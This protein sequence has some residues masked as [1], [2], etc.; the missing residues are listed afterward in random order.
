M[1]FAE[2]YRNGFQGGSL[3]HIVEMSGTTKGALFHHF[4]GK[5]ELG[6]AVVDEVIGPLL[7]HRWLNPVAGAADPIA[8]MKK[9]FRDFVKEDLENGFWLQ[10]CP[11]NNLAQ[12]MSPLDEG[13]RAR[14]DK[15]YGAWRQQYAAALTAGMK[16]GHVKK[17]VSA[18]NAAT[19]IVASQMGIWGTAKSSQCRELMT[20]A[21]EALC[22]YL[23]SLRPQE[24]SQYKQ[25]A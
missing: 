9:A 1:A 16:A 24:A 25:G 19:L 8:A 20:Q 11:L 12:E 7:M 13:F 15:L 6:Y 22:E 10:G 21:C 4:A 23:D 2:F 3:N 18:P 17:T 14:I 5:S